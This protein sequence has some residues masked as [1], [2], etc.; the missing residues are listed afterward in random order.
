MREINYWLVQTS[1]VWLFDK[2]SGSWKFCITPIF[3]IAN[4]N[5]TLLLSSVDK[6]DI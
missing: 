6:H 2:K 5:N 4:D 3:S 1:C